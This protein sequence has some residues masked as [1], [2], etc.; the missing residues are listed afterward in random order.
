M[1]RALESKHP[2]TLSLTGAQGVEITWRA[3]G[4]LVAGQVPG[5]TCRLT[6]DPL[7]VSVLSQV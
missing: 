5:L 3:L 1:G 7:W 2:H 4:P 6:L